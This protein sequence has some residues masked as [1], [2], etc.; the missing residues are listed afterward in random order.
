ME[1]VI[2]GGSDAGI[3]AALGAREIDPDIRPTLVLADSYP[4][5]SICGIPFYLSGEIPDWRTLA[6]RDLAEIESHGI[7]VLAEHRCTEIDPEKKAVRV[8][9]SSGT[10]QV[11][12]YDK[13]VV[14]TGA[15]S[16]TPEIPGLDLPGVFFLRWM[17]D[18]F[19]MEKYMQKRLPESIIIIG[20]GYIGME[21][22]DAM[23]RQGLSVTML[24]YGPTVL[25]T[26]D[27]DMAGHVANEL[28]KNGVRVFTGIAAGSIESL[29]NRLKVRGRRD[30][31]DDFEVTG[32]MVLVATGSRPETAPA[33]SAGIETGFAGAI[34][35]NSRMETSVKD[36]YAAGDCAE[37]RHRMLDKN[38][39]L[40]LGTTAHKQGRVAGANA[41]GGSREFAGSLGTQCVKVFDR[42]AAR[43]GLKESEAVSVDFSPASTD[44]D[45]P[46]H[47]AYYPGAKTL[48]IRI[49]G[50]RITGKLL[51]AQIIGPY[52]AEIAKRID[53]LATALYHD[54]RVSDLSD[55]D[56]SYTPPLSSPLDPV[57]MAAAA[58]GHMHRH[59]SSKV[60]DPCR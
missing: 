47:K 25:A 15:K 44:L 1:L 18:C 37:T 58:W 22:A 43:T 26:L 27:P 28:I 53:I 42:V 41:A 45:V 34:R 33:V 39:W 29:E 55:L 60:P 35:V 30:G 40:P 4:N 24:E 11:I 38:I 50:D 10:Y 57:Q 21:M 2:I 36:I 51:G 48:H 46:D 5:F 9:T 8:V 59:G 12:A 52:G 16:T 20:A 54:M 17:D 19:A 31:K 56:L 7:S 6:H 13:L 14:C 32:D 23:V 3:S 49:T